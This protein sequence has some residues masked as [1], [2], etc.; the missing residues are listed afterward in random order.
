[1]SKFAQAIGV[2][3]LA[4]SLQAALQAQTNNPVDVT[5]ST[6]IVGI[7]EGQ[8][9]QLNALNPAI[10][11]ANCNGVVN[12][13]AGDGTI[14]KTNPV[15]VAPGTSQPTMID[16]VKDLSLTAGERREIRATISIAAA[17]PTTTGSSDTPLKPVCRLI[18]T[19]EIFTTSD[20][21]TLVTLGTDH[22]VPTPA[23]T[24]GS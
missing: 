7:A 19:L 2:F 12:I 6:G 20:G 23:V 1:M 11:G 5:R 9:A 4:F 21:H 18:G 8:T 10:S 13:I 24:P 17:A 14:L 22:E 15:N 3:A 16:S